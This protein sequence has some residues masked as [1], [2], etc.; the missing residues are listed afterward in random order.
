MN[1]ITLER[2]SI[3]ATPGG[4]QIRSIPIGTRITFDID[5]GSWY[6]VLAV[7]GFAQAGYVNARSVRVDTVVTPPPPPPTG[8]HITNIIDVY[9]DGTI[10]VK[11]Q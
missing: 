2:T 3:R 4:E 11:P 1:G 9:S 6:K 10:N 8:K 5:I 7:D